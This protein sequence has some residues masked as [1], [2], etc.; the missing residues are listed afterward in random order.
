VSFDN[1]NSTAVIGNVSIPSSL[2][3]DELW[4][5]DEINLGPSDQTDQITTSEGQ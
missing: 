1:L 4:G 5:G 3:S 2:G